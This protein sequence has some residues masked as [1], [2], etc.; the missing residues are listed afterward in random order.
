[1]PGLIHIYCGEGK[2]KTTAA[3]GLAVRC[4]GSGRKGLILQFLKDGKSSEFAALSHVPG[5]EAVPQT[6]T[7]GFTWTL[8]PEEKQAAAA[9]YT[10]LLEDA[11]CRAGD[12]DLLIL[13]DLGS[14]LTTQFTQSALYELVNTRLVGEKHTVISSNLSMEEAARRYAPQ[15]ASRLDG[16]YHV[17]HFFGDDIR[18]L[19]KNR[20]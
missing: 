20:L 1:M 12:F 17:L 18:L 15:I 6:K 2:G 16:E 9:Y 8:T 14:E 13:D 3:I 11:F 7:F 10:S 4:A 5:I 19:R